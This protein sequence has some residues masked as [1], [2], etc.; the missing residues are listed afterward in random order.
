VRLALLLNPTAV[1]LLEVALLP[2]PNA[3]EYMPLAVLR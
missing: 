1:E 3:E 2:Y